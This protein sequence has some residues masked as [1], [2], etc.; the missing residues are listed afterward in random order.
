[1]NRTA[2]ALRTIVRFY[3]MPA[4]SILSATFAFAAALVMAFQ[5]D[6]LTGSAWTH[7]VTTIGVL[8][9]LAFIHLTV[10]AVREHRAERA[11]TA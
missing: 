4:T 10:W 3:R 11:V 2:T 9:A 7:R 6:S 8:V 5:L 1:M